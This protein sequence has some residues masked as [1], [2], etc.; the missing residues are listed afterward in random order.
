MLPRDPEIR[1][2]TSGWH[3]DHWI[4][5][6]YPANTAHTALLDR[7]AEHFDSVEINTAFYRLPAAA[8]FAAWRDST[9]DRFISACKASRYITHMRKLKDPTV[10]V[11]RFLEAALKLGPKLG[12]ILFQLPPKWRPNVRRL[13]TFLEALPPSRRYAFEFRDSR[14]FDDA[15][16]SALERHGCAFCVYDLAGTQSPAEVTADFAYVRLHG[17]A[18]AYRGNYDDAALA[19]WARR[20]IDW[21]AS[22][23]DVFCY[24]DND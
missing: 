13:E 12:P 3:Y 16:L 23:R 9:P 22:G 18:G 21:R 2:G 6:F 14:W 20:L 8:T 19:R 11:A 7:Y 24:F 17:P 4:G 15:V 10:S 5:R 1:I